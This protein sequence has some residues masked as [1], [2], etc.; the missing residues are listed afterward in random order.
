[1]GI[2]EL[3]NAVLEVLADSPTHGGVELAIGE[4]DVLQLVKVLLNGLSDI[5]R[6]AST[7][8]DG[9]SGGT[10]TAIGTLASGL[11]CP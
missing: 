4:V 3:G 1:M 11:Y 6:C 10:D 7:P 5:G 2:I 9:N 8:G